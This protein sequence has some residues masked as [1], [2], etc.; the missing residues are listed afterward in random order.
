MA[1][2]VVAAVYGALRD[3]AARRGAVKRSS[4]VVAVVVS[5]TIAMVAPAAV[6]GAAR[7]AWC[8]HTCTSIDR[9]IYGKTT[10]SPVVYG[11]LRGAAARRDRAEQRG[12]R[13]GGE[14]YVC[15]GCSRG[16]TPGGSRWRRTSVNRLIMT[17]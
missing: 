1:E 17:A 9:L 8:G 13:G 15:G 10:T 4:A 7:G 2:S 16:G 3:A 5:D 6:P 12:G 14:R 11:V